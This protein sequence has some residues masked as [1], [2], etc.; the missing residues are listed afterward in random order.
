MKR[1]QYGEHTLK[2]LK[3]HQKYIEERKEVKDK[4]KINKQKMWAEFGEKATD[5]L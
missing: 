3:N 5:T 1:K 2:N 4:I